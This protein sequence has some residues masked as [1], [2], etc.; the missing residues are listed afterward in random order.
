MIR[1]ILLLLGTSAWA[2]TGIITP[3]NA[4]GEWE[5]SKAFCH[6]GGLGD[7][8]VPYFKHRVNF[9]WGTGTYIGDEEIVMNMGLGSY[10]VVCS[11]FAEGYYSLARNRLMFLLNSSDIELLNCPITKFLGSIFGP[12]PD[13]YVQFR[14]QISR[15]GQK[16]YTDDGG[17]GVCGPGQTLFTEYER[18]ND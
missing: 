5:A 12:A 2:D 16:L 13:R 7:R 15:D 10:E 11:I 14:F 9:E 3:Q 18:V 1:A 8:N 4:M 6:G 17:D